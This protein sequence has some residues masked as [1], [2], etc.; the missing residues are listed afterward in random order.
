V[1]NTIF[2]DVTP[3]SPFNFTDVSDEYTASFFKVEEKV[4]CFFLDLLF[5]P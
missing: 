2:W 4:Y 5:G 1:K 3:Y